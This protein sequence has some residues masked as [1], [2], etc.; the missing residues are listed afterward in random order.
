MRSTILLLAA[1]CINYFAASAQ[2]PTSAKEPQWVVVNKLDYANTSLDKD[3]EDGYI[4]VDYERQ[5]S[6]AEQAT[7]IRQSSRIISEAGVQ[8][9]SQVSV[10][11]DP[12]FQQLVFHTIRIFRNGQIINKLDLQKITTVHQESD[13]DNFI[14]NGTVNAL[15]VVDDVRKGDVLEYSY[16]LKGFNPVFESKYGTTIISA[17]SSPLYNLY[18]SVLVPQGRSISIKNNLDT[19]Q[20]QIHTQGG[21][22][23]YVWHKTL[24]AP[25]HP[26]DHYPSWYD[27]YPE[28][29][30]G[31][32]KSWKEVNDW[33]V[34]LFP[35]KASLSPALS[36]KIKEIATADS[37]EEGRAQAALRF[38]QDDIRYM[39]IEMGEHSHRP[40]TPDKVMAQRFGDCKEKSYLLC[41]MLQAMGMEASPV[42]IS[43]DDNKAL[44][45][46]LPGLQSFN[47][48]TVRAKVKGQYYWFDPT[49]S[50]QRGKLQDIYYPD[51]QCGLVI[52]DT[53]TA[54]TVIPTNTNG[55]QE[56]K[57]VFNIPNMGGAAQLVVTS[58]YTGYCA[59]NQREQ[60]KT[61]SNYDILK[62]VQ[63][64]YAYNF[65]KI[66]G[67]S[68]V[69]YDDEK[70]GVVTRKAYF[71]LKDI[72]EDDKGAKK[73]HLQP[74]VIGSAMKKPDDKIRSMP[75]SIT[76][77]AKYHE[78]VEVNLPEDW[79]V[80]TAGT[81]ANCPA[82]SFTMASTYAFRQL[83][84]VYDYVAKKDHI[85]PAETDDLL[86]AVKKADDNEGFDL[87]YG[88][89]VD[90]KQLQKNSGNNV[91]YVM[92]A[93]V[94]LIGGIVWWSQRMG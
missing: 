9:R 66:N 17:G 32:Y 15:L 41:T 56:V 64:F 8:N 93:I 48:C 68:L 78:E 51:Y 57:E 7:Y 5:V 34:K 70:T 28:I 43:T 39:G 29:M 26:Q 31:E 90:K 67:D 71:T 81:Y 59:D 16:T 12:S 24:M 84:I 14:Y 74:F 79:N 10:S 52:T 53:T 35:K 2:K 46:H 27:P 87:T 75:Y 80:D 33:A 30:L 65:E 44:L 88:D 38:V 13:L 62:A 6:L 40:A 36:Q 55:T 3:A 82:F 86:A 69:Y 58:T 20:P 11:F 76:Y 42:L 45:A 94:V 21:Q 49:I 19:I 37:T 23:A 91:A 89:S 61:S 73:L 4:D 77:P 25:V 83:R 60:Y 50:Y 18:F 92:V 63:K 1:I 72:W 22:T 47:H 54:L 85:L